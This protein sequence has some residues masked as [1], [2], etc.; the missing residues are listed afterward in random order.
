ME[1]K[2]VRAGRKVRHSEQQ[3][4]VDAIQQRIAA[5]EIASLSNDTK[6]AK[7]LSEL[8]L[9]VDRNASVLVK[10][11]DNDVPSDCADLLGGYF[12]EKCVEFHQGL[13]P[14]VFIEWLSVRTSTAPRFSCQVEHEF[15]GETVKV[16]GYRRL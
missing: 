16:Y 4:R 9:S 3:R 11:I 12:A 6:W 5:G 8:T 7:I 2:K 14:Y 13:L 10:L 1:T 15:D